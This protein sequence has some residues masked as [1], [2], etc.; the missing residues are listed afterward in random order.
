MNADVYRGPWG[1]SNCREES[2]QVVDR[3]CDCSPGLNQLLIIII[4][5]IIS[6]SAGECKASDMYAGQLEDVLK[7]CTP[8]KIAGFI[9]E[10]IQV[11]LI[12]K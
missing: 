6:F 8:K 12:N 10:Y 11:R 2:S 7:H 3:T 1:G 4:I 9:V 5:I